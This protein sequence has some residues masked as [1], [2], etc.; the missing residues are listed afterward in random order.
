MK[1]RQII[2]IASTIAILFVGYGGCSMLAGLKKAP[3]RKALE[4]TYRLVKTMVVQNDTLIKLIAVNGKLIAQEKV[5]IFP[6]V[7]GKLLSSSK[8]FKVGQQFSKGEVLLAIDGNESLLNLKSQRSAFISALSQVLPDVKIDYPDAFD[9]WKTFSDQIDPLKPLPSLPEVTDAQLKNFLSGR[10]LYQQY[11]AIR[12]LED[13]QSKFTILAPFDG[14]VSQGLVNAGTVL[15]AGQK[16][17][18]FMKDGV[19]EFEAAIPGKDAVDI[20]AGDKVS[21]KIPGSSRPYEGRIIRMASNMDPNN[22]RVSLYARVEGSELKEGLYLEGTI[23]ASQINNAIAINHNLVIDDEYVY[24][25]K[26]TVLAKK[27]VTVQDKFKEN[28]LV[29]GLEE[30]DLLL[31]Q[32]IQGAYEGMLVKTESK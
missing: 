21:L 6:E 13:R 4:K 12:S 32:V 10:N 2:I 5:E 28:A 7:T 27:P 3:E 1:K 19:F 18:E 11:F 24:V 29:T 8:A 26:D 20:N 22:Q 9:A 17:G 15:R 23:E 25:V 14:S 16:V 30:G 31:N